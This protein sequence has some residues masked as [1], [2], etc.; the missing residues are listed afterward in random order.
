M[1]KVHV[2][3]IN[4]G[5]KSV[6]DASIWKKMQDNGTARLLKVIPAPAE[7]PGAK[8]PKYADLIQLAKDQRV[9]GDLTDALATYQQF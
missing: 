3:G 7:A 6:I 4:T 5:N 2:Q 8:A 9:A 1:S